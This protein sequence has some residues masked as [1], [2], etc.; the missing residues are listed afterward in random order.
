[1]ESVDSQVAH[2]TMEI[3]F[4]YGQSTKPSKYECAENDK[5]GFCNTD[6]KTVEDNVRHHDSLFLHFKPDLHLI[7][8]LKLLEIPSQCL[9]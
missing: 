4:G 5:T 1:M 8:D 6:E 2:F 3:C 7:I 9:F